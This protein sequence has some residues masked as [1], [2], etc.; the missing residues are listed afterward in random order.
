MVVQSNWRCTN[1]S[2]WINVLSHGVDIDMSCGPVTLVRSGAH[3]GKLPR[4]PELVIKADDI[5]KGEKYFEMES[6]EIYSSAAAVE[7]STDTSYVG[8]FHSEEQVDNTFGINVKPPKSVQLSK[9]ILKF[10]SLAAADQF[11]VYFVRIDGKAGVQA[12]AVQQP[13]SAMSGM[14][15]SLIALLA[16]LSTSNSPVQ[17]SGATPTSDA[18]IRTTNTTNTTNTN[19]L[20]VSNST[21]CVVPRHT[22]TASTTPLNVETNGSQGQ[23]TINIT[24]QCVTEKQVQQMLFEHEE[25]MKK[26]IESQ[27]QNMRMDMIKMLARPT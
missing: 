10:F 18:N 9:I 8:S 12:N 13:N 4:Y 3:D 6:I 25:R 22:D 5:V 1:S 20:N 17:S 21:T 11:D 19:R 2:Q 15:G 26:Y 27:F 14:P 24:H 7:V 23:T 16:G